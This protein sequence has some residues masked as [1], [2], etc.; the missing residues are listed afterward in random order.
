MFYD[1]YKSEILTSLG[2]VVPLALVAL[3]RY[4]TANIILQHFTEN[5]YYYVILTLLAYVSYQIVRNRQHPFSLYTKGGSPDFRATLDL[6]HSLYWYMG[7]GAEELLRDVNIEEYFIQRRNSNRPIKSLRFL[8]LNPES[9]FFTE[10][11]KE[12]NP[13][14][15]INAIAYAKK[16]YLKTLHFSLAALPPDIAQGYEIRYYDEKPIWLLQ[17]FDTEASQSAAMEPEGVILSIHIPRIHSQFSNQHI[18]RKAHSRHMFDSFLTFFE[19]VW[20]RSRPATIVGELPPTSA[21]S[22][23]S[24]KS[25]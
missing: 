15:D 1:R 9:R 10:R 5:W 25:E 22:V 6:G 20:D 16:S 13:H 23:V 4:F 8:L 3:G 18:C 19:A 17:F 21:P 14:G 12:V 11:L 7:M 2:V 24:E